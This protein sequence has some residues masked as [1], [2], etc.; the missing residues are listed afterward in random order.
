MSRVSRDQPLAE[1]QVKG[2]HST[3]RRHEAEAEMSPDSFQHATIK[4]ARTMLIKYHWEMLTVR[5]RRRSKCAEMWVF[6]VG[7]NDDEENVDFK[8][9]IYKKM[10]YKIN[11]HTLTDTPLTRQFLNFHGCENLTIL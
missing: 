4:A 11:K 9:N 8:D 2:D 1:G 3:S 10:I 7:L 6:E 5:R